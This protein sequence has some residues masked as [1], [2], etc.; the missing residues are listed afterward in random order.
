MS[1]RSRVFEVNAGTLVGPIWFI[2]GCS[3][4]HLP[5]CLVG[6]AAGAE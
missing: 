1:S 2:G 3:P 6:G 5:S 4:L